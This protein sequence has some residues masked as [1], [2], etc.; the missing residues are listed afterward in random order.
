MTAP[1][2]QGSTPGHPGDPDL[3]LI[4]GAPANKTT[5]PSEP[6][7]P[8]ECTPAHEPKGGLWEHPAAPGRALNVER[9]RTLSPLDRG[10]HFGDGLF[11]T[12]ACRLGRPRFLSLHLERLTEGCR[13]LRI[14]H[15]DVT[16]IRREVE[17]AASDAQNSL[18]KLIVTRGPA[19]ARGYGISGQESATRVLLR[20]PWPQEDTSSRR[21]GVR[22]QIASLRLGENPALAGMKHLNRLEQVLARSEVPAAEAA[23][24]IL[25]S[26]SGHLVSGTMS[27]VFVVR[28]GKLITPR[29]DRCGVA[30]VMRRVVMRAATK[31]GLAVEEGILS[32]S[33]LEN[34]AEIFL[35]NA[36]I[37][38]WPVRTLGTRTLATG[39]VTRRLQALIAPLLEN[40]VDA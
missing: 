23:E 31:A 21:D 4:N 28:T 12:I 11:E 10:L 25:F 33:D 17:A 6:A 2:A 3:V 24:V 36:R 19:V 35:T 1:G 9:A 27:N 40:P 26:G 38:I 30:G 39:A 13:R 37:G 32:G 14:D 7:A 29:I 18:I 20:Y 22:V 5:S 8:D 16:V 34:V 15:G